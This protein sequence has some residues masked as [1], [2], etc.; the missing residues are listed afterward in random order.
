[1]SLIP[2]HGD[3]YLIQHNV[4][5]FVSDLQQVSGF[6]PVLWFF[7]QWNEPSQYNWK[8][9]ESGIKHHNRTP[10]INRRTPVIWIRHVFI[11][12]N[13]NATIN[14]KL[15]KNLILINNYLTLTNNW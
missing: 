4:I 12:L 14:Y 11:G 9:V 6:H 5:K 1:M 7:H 10:M 3:V 15:L 8:I 13:Q 2:S